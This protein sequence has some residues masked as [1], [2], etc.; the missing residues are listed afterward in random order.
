MWCEQVR[1]M[2]TLHALGALDGAGKLTSRGRT[3]ADF[4]LAPQYALVLLCS[5]NFGCSQVRP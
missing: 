1:A 5:V 2:E 4:P 3:M